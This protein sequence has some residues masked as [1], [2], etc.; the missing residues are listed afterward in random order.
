MPLAI[1]ITSDSSHHKSALN[2]I[3][4]CLLFLFSNVWVPLVGE[5]HVGVKPVRMIHGGV[6]TPP[7]L[8]RG[9]YLLVAFLIASSAILVCTVAVSLLVFSL[10]VRE[11]KMNVSGPSRGVYFLIPEFIH[12]M[13]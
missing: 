10:A 7:V 8:H 5:V 11:G 6:G 3:L 1:L 4:N 9:V 12:L 13:S 2:I